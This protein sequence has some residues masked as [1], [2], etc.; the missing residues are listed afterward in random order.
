MGEQS[1]TTYRF[2]TN[3]LDL[4]REDDDS[5]GSPCRCRI[6]VLALN[7]GVPVAWGPA[8]EVQVGCR[9]KKVLSPLKY[10][11]YGVQLRRMKCTVQ[12][13]LSWHL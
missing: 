1:D 4:G 2:G 3:W 6:S 11:I 12:Y 13:K 7:G 5:G 8:I 10:A 9:L